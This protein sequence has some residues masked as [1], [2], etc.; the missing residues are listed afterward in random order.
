MQEQIIPEK[1]PNV[2]PPG[3]DEDVL[4]V[5]NSK[6]IN[7]MI[8]D[9]PDD[10]E[11]LVCGFKG[12]PNNPPDY[13]WAAKPA[14]VKQSANILK[15]NDLNAYM[16]VSSFYRASDDKYRRRKSCFAALHCLM[17]D[18]LGSGEGA[19][20]PIDRLVLKPTALIETSPDNFQAYLRLAKPIADFELADKLIRAMIQQGL[21]ADADPGM[22]GVTRYGRLPNGIN[23]KLKYNG[24]KVR[25]Q[26]WNP[27]VAYTVEEIAEAFGLDL[28]GV[29]SGITR[30]EVHSRIRAKRGGNAVRTKIADDPIYL[31][32]K[33]KGV[34]GRRMRI[35]DKGEGGAWIEMQCPWIDEHTSRAG[36][37]A[38]YCIGG[39]FK[40]HHGHCINKGIRDVT[41]KLDMADMIPMLEKMRAEFDK[42]VL[43]AT[44][45]A[46][47]ATS[48]YLG[49]G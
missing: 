28:S 3:L 41:E 2:K 11:A 29:G 38:A 39:G 27:G 9:V 12:D 15:R 24:W 48:P 23:G 47:R 37:G 33:D 49:G 35:S 34:F 1:L 16:V 36:T 6:F 46:I 17:L 5:T 43:L 10:A 13:A 4:K 31:A 40:C 45:D 20:A 30:R 21:M 14:F 7:T 22:A 44:F 19:K 18:D 26:D 32:L 25:L 8:Q 42:Q